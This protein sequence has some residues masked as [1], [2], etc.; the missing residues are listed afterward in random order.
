MFPGV[1]YIP[2]TEQRNTSHERATVHYS[3]A[4][5]TEAVI[6]IQVEFSV[7]PELRDLEAIASEMHE[8]FPLKQRINNVRMAVNA[9]GDGQP[10]SSHA[11]SSA[12]GLRLSSASN[13]RIVQVRM[14]GLSFSHMPPYTRWSEFVDQMR[15][16]WHRYQEKLGPKKVTRLAV[17]YINRIAL[18]QGVDLDDYLNLTPRLLKDAGTAVEGYFM[19]LVLPQR[20]LGPSWKAI[21]NTGLEDGSTS[22]SMIVLFDVD[23][24]CDVDLPPASEEVWNLLGKLR[25]RKNQIFE[26]AI[27]DSVR[28]MIK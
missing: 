2:G 15:P 18:P 28:E 14:Q 24:F 20:D 27:T 7:P 13:E 21:V 9:A 8:T 10:L 17:R 19:Q 16:I 25:D 1:R 12:I 3:R 22:E 26:A 5:I 11:T 6:D 4:P 23:L